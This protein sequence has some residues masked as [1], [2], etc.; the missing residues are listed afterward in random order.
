MTVPVTVFF[1]LPA[2]ENMSDNVNFAAK[3]THFWIPFEI[4]A[5]ELLWGV[6]SCKH[7]LCPSAV[8]HDEYTPF[9]GACF[10]V[11]SCGGGQV[12]LVFF[13]EKLMGGIG[14]ALNFFCHWAKGGKGKKDLAKKKV[15]FFFK[16]SW[17]V[18]PI[19]DGLDENEQ[20]FFCTSNETL[21]KPKI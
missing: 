1:L 16:K 4:K 17:V 18:A 12:H 5:L 20:I 11:R 14:S 7:P 3:K 2:Q 8:A 13:G 19:F 9:C 21:W 6:E 15:D 10:G